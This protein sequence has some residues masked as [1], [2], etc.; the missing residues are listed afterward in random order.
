MSYLTYSP[1]INRYPVRGFNNPNAV[2]SPDTILLDPYAANVVLFIKGDGENNSTTIVD[3][4]PTPKAITV[5]GNAQISTAQSKYGGSSIYFDGTGGYLQLA[6]SPDWTISGDYT[7][8]AWL[9]PSDLALNRYWITHWL[10][11]GGNE[12]NFGNSVLNA[13]INRNGVNYGIP[14]HPSEFTLSINTWVHYCVVVSSNTMIVFLDGVEVN[15]IAISPD[16]NESTQPLIIGA[17]TTTVE[18][19]YMGYIDSLRI[20]KGVARYTANFDPEA[21]TFLDL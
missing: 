7:V 12:R 18:F 2:K 11:G 14:S 3:S 1:A 13:S 16:F 4:S 15:R 19:P 9:Y 10:G 20:T 21:D 6:D 5:N 8:E 17:Y